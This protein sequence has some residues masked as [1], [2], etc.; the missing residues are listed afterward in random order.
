[1]FFDPSQPEMPPTFSVTLATKLDLN[2]AVKIAKDDPNKWQE[3]TLLERHELLAGVARNLRK[4]RG[5][6]IGIAAA[7]C[8]K[9][10]YESDPEISEA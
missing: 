8:G 1:M 3:T 5:D 10:F 6:L 9:T 7:V 2:K 4:R